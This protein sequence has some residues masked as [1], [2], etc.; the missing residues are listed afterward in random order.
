MA[1]SLVLPIAILL[2]WLFSSPL[3]KGLLCG[4]W[5]L[6]GIEYIIHYLLFS[7]SFLI[8]HQEIFLAQNI[9]TNRKDKIFTKSLVKIKQVVQ[10]YIP[11]LATLPF[12][13]YHHRINFCLSSA[14]HSMFLLIL[15]F[16]FS[17]FLRVQID[18]Y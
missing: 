4:P 1:F 9:R 16:D 13:T 15:L 2:I 17:W 14:T 7:L 3:L 6:F 8:P 5:R 12:W 18:H 11:N 10:I